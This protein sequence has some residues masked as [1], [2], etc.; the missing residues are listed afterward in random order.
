MGT[1]S[2]HHH[3]CR[4]FLASLSDY[5]DGVLDEALCR[6][7]E[8]HMAGCE[9]CRI[10]INTLAKTVELYQTAPAPALPQDIQ[11]RLFTSLDLEK[12]LRKQG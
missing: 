2:E 7:I 5:V 3:D 11:R 8:A 9:D 12:F 1:S 6:E 10:V 4:R